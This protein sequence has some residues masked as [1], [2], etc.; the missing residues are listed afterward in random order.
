MEAE[1]SHL[2]GGEDAAPNDHLVLR[3]KRVLIPQNR[4]QLLYTLHCTPVLPRILVTI[5]RRYRFLRGQGGTA[6]P[7]AIRAMHALMSWAMKRK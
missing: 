3:Q 7:L 5:R 1:A 2:N 6:L 4:L